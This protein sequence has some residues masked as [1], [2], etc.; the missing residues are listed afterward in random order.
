[1]NRRDFLK[2]SAGTALVPLLPFGVLAGVFRR[3]VPLVIT[4]Y[5]VDHNST[6]PDVRMDTGNRHVV[7]WRVG[8]TGE[9]HYCAFFH[10]EKKQFPGSSTEKEVAREMIS[11][12]HHMKGIEAEALGWKWDKKHR[13]VRV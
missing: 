1:M 5:R 9:Q 13:M 8:E 3:R 7:I 11:Y 12:M 6:L 2:A 10:D 4:E